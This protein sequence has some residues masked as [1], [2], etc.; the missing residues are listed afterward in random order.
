MLS[1]A[2]NCTTK[3]VKSLS[4]SHLATNPPSATTVNFSKTKCP[5]RRS[6]CL[7]WKTITWKQSR[8]SSVYKEGL[9]TSRL[10]CA[11]SR[12]FIA[13]THFHCGRRIDTQNNCRFAVR[14]IFANHASGNGIA[15]WTL[16]LFRWAKHEDWIANFMWPTSFPTLCC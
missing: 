12:S 7:H 9:L 3:N 13:F 1:P 11:T 8:R 16:H 6:T 15:Q 4:S 2:S 5:L 14:V 10:W